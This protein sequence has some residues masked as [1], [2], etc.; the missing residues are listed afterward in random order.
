ML[1]IIVKE[2]LAACTRIEV[3]TDTDLFSALESGQAQV[4]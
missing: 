2:I 3:Q 4:L 1:D